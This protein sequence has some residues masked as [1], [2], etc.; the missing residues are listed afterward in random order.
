MSAAPGAVGE[1]VRY[2]ADTVVTCDADFTMIDQGA[3][4]VV[5]GRISFIGPAAEAPHHAGRVEVLGGLV[6]PGLVNTHAHTPMTLVRG[7]GDGLPLMR[8]LTEVM[9]PREGQ[10]T[11]DDVRWGMTLGSI[12]MLKAGVTTSCEMYLF[13][14]AVVAAAQ[15]AGIRLLMTPGILAALH[16]DTFGA[17]SSRIDAIV[18]FH[19]RMHDPDGTLTVG[20]APHSAYDLSL[21]YCAEI[22]AAARDLDALLHIHVAE[23][24]EEGAELEAAHGGRSTVQLLADAGVFGGRVLTAHS[25]WIDDADIDTYADLGVAVAHCPVSNMKL[26]SGTARVPEMLAKGVTVGLGTDG[27]ASND[28]LD[29]WQELKFAPLLAR[30]TALDAS[31]M[32][33]RDAL[34][35]ATRHGAKA[36]GLD[37]V[38]CLVVGNRADM[39]RLDID[40][41]AFIPVTAP[42]ELVAHLAWSAGARHVTD[43][44][45]QGRQVVRDRV[46]I[47]VDE[48][49]ARNEGRLRGLRLARD[50]GT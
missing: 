20:F 36:L 19:H 39:I 50:S 48:Q 14:D 26:G 42:E 3:I 41:P 40:D 11:L 46:C 33:P 44:W 4:D 2:L 24:R 45:V 10:M 7:G 38:G 12:E 21:D 16:A 5:D 18:D 32:G 8:W 49:Q 15:D 25:V 27:P 28:D 47:T 17:E 30:V 35:M 22:A 6:M 29:L 43:V 23:T 1:V 34:T 31:V 37:E 9:W 13:E